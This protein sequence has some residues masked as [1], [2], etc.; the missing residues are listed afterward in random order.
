MKCFAWVLPPVC[1][2]S[3][4]SAPWKSGSVTARHSTERKEH[5][6]EVPETYEWTLEFSDGRKADGWSSY[7]RAGNFL[8]V[9]VEQGEIEF[10]PSTGYTGQRGSTPAGPMDFTHVKQQVLQIDG[11][12][13]AILKNE[14]SRVPGEMGRRDI[15]V[16]R[17]IVEAGDTG[18]AHEFG[19]FR[20]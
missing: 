6:T 9:K 19:R 20:Y 12:A 7:G 16:I 3:P 10:Q 4:G 2:R 18:R 17:G 14:P 11:Q 1:C 8:C 15:R 13:E 5:F